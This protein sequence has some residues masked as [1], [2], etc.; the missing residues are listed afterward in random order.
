[1][2]A[3]SN[4]F[5]GSGYINTTEWG[6][7]FDWTSGLP[8]MPGSSLKGALLAYLEFLAEGTVVQDWKPKTKD[9]K[10]NIK[11]KSPEELLKMNDSEKGFWYAVK[12]NDNVK[13]KDDNEYEDIWTKDDIIK[14]FGPQGNISDDET[15]RG[16][17]AFFDVLPIDFKGFE[18]EVIT[19]H[20]GEYYSSNGEKPPADIYS[21]VPNHFLTIKAG[22][23]FQFAFKILDDN[24][25]SVEKITN[26]IKEAGKYWGFG[27]KT[28]SGY[29]MFK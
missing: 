22:S 12:L 10:D 6:L 18:L 4:F 13:D 11:G 17:V 3:L 14:V 5:V 23:T 9:E 16:G 8:Y 21:P 2:T 27:A 7:S 25:I 26:L 15:S 29:G 1:M 20:Y 24:G 28:S 19:P